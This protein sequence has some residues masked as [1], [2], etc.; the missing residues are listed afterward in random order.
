M[1]FQFSKIHV[2]SEFI[3]FE[4][5]EKVK[6][7]ATFLKNE[8]RYR[9]EIFIDVRRRVFPVVLG[10]ENARGHFRS[11]SEKNYNK[12]I[13]SSFFAFCI[14]YEIRTNLYCDF[15]TDSGYMIYSENKQSILEILSIKVLQLYSH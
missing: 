5:F 7:S 2:L 14:F 9:A 6:F 1:P 10:Q 4:L 15:L 11:S 12:L 8:K 3:V 13:F